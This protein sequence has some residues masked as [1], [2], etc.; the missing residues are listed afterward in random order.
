MS[1][2]AQP[3]LSSAQ[4]ACL[5][6]FRRAQCVDVHCHCLPGLDDGPA[7][8]DEALALCRA[9]VDDGVTT[10]LA[11]PHQL[12]CYDGLVDPAT[13]RQAVDDLNANLADRGIT[14][15][16]AHPER[17]GFLAT[18]PDAVLPWAESGALLQ[19]T[20]ASLLGDA[21]ELERRVAWHWL[22]IGAASPGAADAHDAD[23]G[24]PLMAA[25]L[26]RAVSLLGHP[27][28]RRV[29]IENPMRVLAG[30]RVSPYSDIVPRRMAR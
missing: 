30:K 18:H 5:R 4:R 14:A 12:G 23:G 9:L 10:A 25:A 16:V 8:L 20:A 21:G 27:A 29:C 7:T 13:I 28:A 22:R 15:I 11:T 6:R 3:P 1:E 2:L 19:V 17:N 24:G 26:D